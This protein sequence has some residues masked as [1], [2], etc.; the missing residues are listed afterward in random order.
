MAFRKFRDIE[1]PVPGV[2]TAIQVLRPG[3]RYDLT[4]TEFTE[5]EDELGREP[6][7]WVEICREVEREKEIYDHYS[8][9]RDRQKNYPDLKEQFDML[10]HDIK[11]GKINNGKW[12]ESIEKIKEM[13]PKPSNSQ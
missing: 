9:E 3:A 7:S 6:P 13:Y 2:D 5:W 11:S 4:N 8:W 12:I 10:Y 1:Y